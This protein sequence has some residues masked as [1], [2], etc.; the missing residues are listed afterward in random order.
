M[1]KALLLFLS[2]PVFVFAGPVYQCESLDGSH[3]Y[4]DQACKGETLKVIDDGEEKHKAMF[5]QAMVQVLAK[6]TQKKATA[7]N[8]S[9]K[10]KAMEVLAM[11]DA[12]KSYAFTQVYAVSTKY[13]GRDVESAL[14]NYQNQASEVIALGAYYYSQ[15]IDANLDGN[16]FSQSGQ[17]LT[18]ALYEMTKGLDLEHQKASESELVRKCKEAKNALNSLAFLYSN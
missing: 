5:T 17:Q 4:Q 10:M 12:A 2:V 18:A 14:L 16:D 8:D 9:T 7:Y 15:G 1:S 6:L 13:C 11:T 3:V